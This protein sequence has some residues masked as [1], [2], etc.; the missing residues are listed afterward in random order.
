MKPIKTYVIIE[1]ITVGIGAYR[2]TLGQIIKLTFSNA[3][4]MSDAY[5]FGEEKN[6]A[7][8]AVFSRAKN[9]TDVGNNIYFYSHI[10]YCKGFKTLALS[11]HYKGMDFAL[12]GE[13]FFDREIT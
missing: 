2:R 8:F 1:D 10:S 9:R 5:A 12:L 7:I 6:N 13:P 3:K 4:Y 11:R